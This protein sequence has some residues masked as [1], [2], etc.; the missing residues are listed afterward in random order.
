MTD[1][2]RPLVRTLPLLRGLA[3]ILALAIVVAHVMGATSHPEWWGVHFYRFLPAA[4]LWIAI[5]LMGCAGLIA[6]RWPAA[7][8]R[9]FDPA[10]TPGASPFEAG[11]LARV[12]GAIAALGAASFALFWRFREAHTLLG[13]GHPLTRNLPLGQ[14]FHPDEPLALELHHLFYALTRGLFERPGRDPAEVA[15]DTVAL[16]SALAGALFVPIAWALA[17]ELEGAARAAGQAVERAV[18]GASERAGRGALLVFVALIAQGYIQLFFGYVENYT[19]YCLVIAAFALVAVRVLEG[20]S[21]LWPAGLLVVLAAALHLAGALLLPAL[22]LLLAHE[23]L[24][25]A[26]RA[27]ALRDLAIGLAGFAMAGIALDRLSPHYDWFAM[28]ARLA[29]AVTSSGSSYG[30]HRPGALDLLNQQLLIGPLGV[31]L[32]L[33]VAAL[34]LL[35]GSARAWKAALWLTLGGAFLVASIIAGDSNL[36][37][38]RNWDLLAPAG[39][40]FTLAGLGLA[41]AAGWTARDRHRWLFLLGAVSLFHTVPWIANNASFDRAFTRFK[42]LPLG[43]GRTQAVVGNVYLERGEV[44]SAAVWFRRSL[45]ENPSN[46]LASFELGRIAMSRGD[47][48]YASNAFK[49]A[50]LARPGTEPYQYLLVG[51]LTRSHRFADARR[52]LDGLLAEDAREPLYW[53]ASAV[54]WQCLGERDSSRAAIAR[55]DAIAPGDSLFAALH[56]HLDRRDGF[57]AALDAVWPPITLP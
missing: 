52:E 45:D 38:A 34:A 10:P 55:A 54:V 1:P 50:L 21:P 41:L 12:W 28:L 16:S 4:T 14:H 6:W 26:R 51:A 9:A 3:W 17:R 15:R 27:A 7:L 29:G 19:L 25:P 22:L 2:P 11:A 5:A 36:G 44:D 56:G 42:S 18:D 33:P 24:R 8:E 53:A 40:V 46:N 47:Y 39:F 49:A 57:P 20:R 35:D 13:D 31:F 37:V 30:F 48:D 32:F 23:L 43:M